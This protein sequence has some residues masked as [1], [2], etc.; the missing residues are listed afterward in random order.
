M[1]DF[2]AL[3]LDGVLVDPLW[4]ISITHPRGRGIS[5]G[6]R[7]TRVWSLTK[8]ESHLFFGHVFNNA[9]LV[10]SL[11]DTVTYIVSVNILSNRV[12]VV[13]ISNGPANCTGGKSEASRYEK[14][15]QEKRKDS[16]S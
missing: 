10:H 9:A 16:E 1:N 8:H 15:D 6:S 4:I 3:K 5:L 14:R 11:R 12:S 13:T 7:L 2:T